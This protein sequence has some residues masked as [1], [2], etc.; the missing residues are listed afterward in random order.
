L[1]PCKH[2]TNSRD[3]RVEALWRHRFGLVPLWHLTNECLTWGEGGWNKV[4]CG[5]YTVLTNNCLTRGGRGLN[6]VK[7]EKYWVKIC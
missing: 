1:P 7:R 3:A 2:D 6:K 5:N 4:K